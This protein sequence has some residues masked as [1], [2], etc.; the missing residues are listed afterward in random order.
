MLGNMENE[1]ILAM[2]LSMKPSK[3]KQR[4]RRRAL[5]RRICLGQLVW[6]CSQK[7]PRAVTGLIHAH[8][9]ILGRPFMLWIKSSNNIQKMIF[10]ANKFE[11]SDSVK[12]YCHVARTIMLRELLVS[13][14]NWGST[15]LEQRSGH[16]E[17]KVCTKYLRY[18]LG[19]AV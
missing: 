11:C 13:P 19:M 15:A 5:S 10:G 18:F 9:P 4:L 17:C 3:E 12:R 8:L 7:E 1:P 14:G 16:D 6:D 2:K